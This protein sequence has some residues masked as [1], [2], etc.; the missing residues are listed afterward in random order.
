M[1]RLVKISRQARWLCDLRSL[2]FC[3]DVWGGK[4][5]AFE[6]AGCT[7]S[8]PLFLKQCRPRRERPAEALPQRV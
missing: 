1:V 8:A 6:V 4:G 2:F 5:A 3:F 7:R